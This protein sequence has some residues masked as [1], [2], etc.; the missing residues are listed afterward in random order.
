MKL[1]NK[2]A[3]EFALVYGAIVF[4]GFFVAVKEGTKPQPAPK[5]KTYLIKEVVYEC[6]KPVKKPKPK[7]EANCK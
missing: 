2:G 4:F 5:P 6:P 7:A 3:I 1:N